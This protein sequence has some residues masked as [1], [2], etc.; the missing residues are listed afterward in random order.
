LVARND[1]DETFNTIDLWISEITGT[2]AAELRSAPLAET[3]Q[4]F[5]WP[6][7]GRPR[8]FPPPLPNATVD[9]APRRASGPSVLRRI[10]FWS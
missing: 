1:D 3:E 6:L 10:I 7:D 9:A 5:R 2:T 4:V 8:R